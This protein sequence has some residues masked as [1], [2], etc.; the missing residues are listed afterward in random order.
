MVDQSCAVGPQ[1]AAADPSSPTGYLAVKYSI[2]RHGAVG[3]GDDPTAAA[4][5]GPTNWQCRVITT[6]EPYREGEF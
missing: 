2:I 6:S 1:H 4:C 5:C 3:Y